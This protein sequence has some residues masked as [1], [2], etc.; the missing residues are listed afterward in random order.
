M[1]TVYADGKSIVTA[2]SKDPDSEVAYGFSFVKHL[3]AG[4][5][6]TGSSWLIN[7]VL[8]TTAQ[9]TIDGL[10]VA[11]PTA[12]PGDPAYAFSTTVTKVWLHLGTLV[13]TYTVTNRYSLSDETVN[14][15]SMYI[16]VG[17]K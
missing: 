6:V 11:S 1:N 15:I 9:T 7:D 17:A 8:I 13:V 2:P 16:T 5:T 10:K 12:M 3:P 14:D 4:V